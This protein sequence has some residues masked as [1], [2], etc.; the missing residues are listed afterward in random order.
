MGLLTSLC[1]HVLDQKSNPLRPQSPKM[2]DSLSPRLSCSGGPCVLT[3]PAP[4]PHP[5]IHYWP[6]FRSRQHFT[7]FLPL[8]PLLSADMCIPRG[9]GSL[10]AAPTPLASSRSGRSLRREVRVSHA[11]AR[12]LSAAR[13]PTLYTRGKYWKLSWE[14]SQRQGDSA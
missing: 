11:H 7:L 4:L 2:C 8:R 6:G 9:Y 10:Q 3:E 1:L 13:A 12:T 5:G 14:M